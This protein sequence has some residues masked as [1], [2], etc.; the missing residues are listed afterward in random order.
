M[1]ERVEEESVDQST[2]ACSQNIRRRNGSRDRSSLDHGP[3]CQN[4]DR[5]IQQECSCDEA[6]RDGEDV[7]LCLV[8][9]E[10]EDVSSTPRNQDDSA[11]E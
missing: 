2:R 7:S 11:N 9:I 1:I 3:F 8:A 6:T 10:H 4:P 5:G